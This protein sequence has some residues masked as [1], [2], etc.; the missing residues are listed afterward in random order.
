MNFRLY[1]PR[2]VPLHYTPSLMHALQSNAT[3][4]I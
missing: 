3:C 1:M 4:V 2:M